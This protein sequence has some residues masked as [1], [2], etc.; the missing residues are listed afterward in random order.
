MLAQNKFLSKQLEILTETIGKLPTKLSTGQPSQSSI[1]QVIGCTICGGAHESDHCIPFEE[2]TQEVSYIGNQQRQGYNQGGF[3]GFQQGPYNQQGQWGS[4]PGNQFN[5]DQ[6]GSSNRPP[7]QGPNIFQ[8]TTK[9]EETLAQFMQVTMSNHKSTESALK[10]LE[11]QVGQLAKQLAEK[12]S[13]S[14]GENTKKNPKEECK[15]VVTKS[16]N[17]MAAEDEDVGALKEQVPL[18]D[19]TVKKKNEENIV[20]EGNYSVMIQKILPPKHKD[21]GSVTIPFSI[22]E[23]TVGKAFIYLGASINLMPLS[24]CRRLGE[25]EIMPTRMTL[26]LADRSITRPYRVIEDVLIRVKQMV[27]PVDFMVM[28]VEEDH[29]VPIILGRPFM[30]TASCVVDM[31]RKTLEMGFEDQKINFDIFEEDKPM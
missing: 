2:Q 1:L 3:L 22:G 10:N 5:K 24:M 7:Q 17:L 18:K 4:H 28:D 6:G 27:F 8:R 26:Q 19:T 11:I 23:V 30:L 12:S 20:V 29:E 9:M 25:L 21:P 14:F 16:R 15:V 13:N 31:G